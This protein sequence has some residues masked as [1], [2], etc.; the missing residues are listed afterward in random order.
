M[1]ELNK[2]HR[3]KLLTPARGGAFKESVL[4]SRK[5]NDQGYAG[6][7]LN[8][9]IAFSYLA[10]CTRYKRGASVRAISAGTG[11]HHKTINNALAGLGRAV[12]KTGSKWFVDKIPVEWFTQRTGG[13]DCDRLYDRL[14][15]IM[16]FVPRRG[17]A[18]KYEST[19]R[20]FGVNHA[21]VTSLVFNKA[22]SPEAVIPDFTCA[23]AGKLLS[24]GAK[25]VRSVIDDLNYSGFIKVCEL[26]RKFEITRCPLTDNQMNMFAFKPSKPI[27]KPV[28]AVE[29]QPRPVGYKYE[30]RGDGFD[31]Y[32]E[33]C[34]KLMQQ[35]FA[36][37]SIRIASELG[38]DVGTFEAQLIAAWEQHYQNQL[39][40]KVGKG[41]FGKYFVKRMQTRLRALFEKRR[42]ADREAQLHKYLSSPEYKAKRAHE[43]KIAEADPSHP[44]HVL[45]D[46]SILSRV[47]FDDDPVANRRRMTAVRDSLSSQCRT[48]VGAMKLPTQESIN[49]QCS[50]RTS[51]MQRAL[52]TLN[53][54]YNQDERATDEMLEAAIDDALVAEGM[55]VLFRK[56]VANA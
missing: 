51:I 16:Y 30:M 18:I 37:Q 19:S 40:G 3:F 10:Y 29:K 4:K 17:A 41:D 11:L 52:K 53:H 31:E 13:E 54:F 45:T 24:I 42:E 2:L 20:R 1:T 26:G 22:R 9:R 5:A 44:G 35:K 55:T 14:A 36:E 6:H 47:R 34:Q 32:R 39:A 21:A 12:V 27:A 28:Q 33:F 8:E 7:I 38:D 43:E 25:T 50:L 56:E 46:E 23:G 15:Y 48:H 49:K